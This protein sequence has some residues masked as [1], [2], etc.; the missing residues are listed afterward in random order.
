MS[1]WP[2]LI[3]TLTM[4]GAIGAYFWATLTRTIKPKVEA[5]FNTNTMTVLVLTIIGMIA[6]LFHLG[7]PFKALNSLLNLSSSWLS[8]EIFF[9]GGFLVLLIILLFLERGKI[10]EN[11]KFY[12]SWL[13]T[14]VGFLAVL[15]MAMLYVV[16]LIPAWQSSFTV[17]SFFVTTFVLGGVIFIFTSSNELKENMPRVDLVILALVILEAIFTPNFLASLGAGSAAAQQSALLFASNYGVLLALKW[18]L[19]LGGAFF[20]L[21]FFNQKTTKQ[22][23]LYASLAAIVIGLIL[24]RYLFYATAVSIGIGLL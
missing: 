3:F 19:T 2:L 14:I 5:K 12:F 9:S 18:I 20:T 6:S 23:S 10:T 1:E 13:I 8:R 16:T 22:S 17:L 11:V 4:Q 21:L 15:S 24:S 7:T